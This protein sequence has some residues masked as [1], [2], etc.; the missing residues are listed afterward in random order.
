MTGASGAG[1]SAEHARTF[2]ARIFS[3]TR[4]FGAAESEGLGRKLVAMSDVTVRLGAEASTV[5]TGSIADWTGKR[6]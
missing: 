6:G 5:C 4:H 3:P 2:L 1:N